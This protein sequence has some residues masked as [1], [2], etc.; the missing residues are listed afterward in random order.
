MA[1]SAAEAIG[2]QQKLDPVF[3]RAVREALFW[4]LTALALVLLI[5]L[6]SFDPS[7]RSFSYTGEPGRVGNLIGPL[8][9]WLASALYLFFG[10]P[11]FLFPVAIGFGAWSGLKRVP[12]APGQGRSTIALRVSGLAGAL[13]SSCGLAALHFSAGV[14]PAGAGGILGSLVGEGLTGAA[15]LLGA[16]L[17][18]LALWFASVHLASGVSWFTV[19]DVLGH[20]VLEGAARLRA[21]FASSRD[22]AVGRESREARESVVREVQKRTEKRTPPRI[23]M[24]APPVVEPSRRVEKER[25]VQLF[26]K[27]PSRDLPALKLLDEPPPRGSSYSP[28]AL[29]AI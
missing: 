18:L 20:W 4:L 28:E 23:E 7:D 5:S 9:A 21:R 10:W 8:G 13:A 6:A 3:A 15:S 27:P 11:A 1:K 24:P 26:A 17:I 19:M 2:S 16:T 25:Q 29:D 12:G 22:Q 14:L